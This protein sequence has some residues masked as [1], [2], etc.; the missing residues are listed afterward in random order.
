M[1]GPARHHLLRSPVGL[2]LAFGFAWA[3]PLASQSP[4]AAPEAADSTE[5]ALRTPT[6]S[7]WA[8]RSWNLL[9]D[10][11]AAREGGFSREG[12]L[13]RF[14]SG[15]DAEYALDL[16]SS[17]FDPWDDAGWAQRSNG[18]RYWSGSINHRVMTDGAQAKVRVGVGG[19]F[20]LGVRYDRETNPALNRDLLRAEVAWGGATG[21]H[22]FLGASLQAEKPDRDLVLGAGW[23]GP[24][25]AARL[26]LHALDAFSNVIY[27]GLGVDPAFA[28]EAT[29]YDG[30]P[31]GI[32]AST[33]V[34]KPDGLGLSLEAG[35]QL[36]TTLRRY[37]QEDPDR[38]WVQDEDFAM[39]GVAADVPL[40][41]RVR[42]GG[43]ATLLRAHRD[44]TPLADGDSEDAFELTEETIQVGLQA[45]A[46][47]WPSLEVRGWAARSWRPERR[48][49]TASG[50]G[51]ESGAPGTGPTVDYL[52]R[53]WSGQL[54]L[55]H[56]TTRHLRLRGAWDFDFREVVRG[57]GQVQSLEPL[58]RNNHRA[59]IEAAWVRAGRFEL[60]LGVRFDT[61]GDPPFDRGPFD[62][63]HGRLVIY[64]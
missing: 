14:D 32:R 64:W 1:D 45:T 20:S 39:V 23:R 46:L 36:P 15:F 40:G 34:G 5:V 51:P 35:F 9:A 55:A 48:T 3:G 11:W 47:P 27:N 17:R 19:R 21:F 26:E 61:D 13:L 58:G 44:R 4:S 63:G 30:M 12:L 10:R 16:I 37:E 43:M 29:D 41:S 49:P 2:L 62:G 33:R 22:T 42:V 52:D 54:Q 59:R 53:A 28:D 18:L 7:E 31:L 6:L 38:G 25:V 56:R 8:D 57:E 50:E 24:T 60:T